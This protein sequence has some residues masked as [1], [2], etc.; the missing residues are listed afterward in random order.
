M[1]KGL[2]LV[3]FL[4]ITLVAIAVAVLVPLA[5]PSLAFWSVTLDYTWKLF[6]NLIAISLIAL[7]IA[8]LLSPLEALGWWAGWYKS[9]LDTSFQDFSQI[10]TP[11]RYIER[12][13]VYLDGIN[14]DEFEYLENVEVF[15][16]QL[17]Q[18]LPNQ[19][20]LGKQIM[21]YSVLN[22]SLVD[23]DRPL[24]F[25]W[26]WVDWRSDN[27]SRGLLDFFVN[28]RNV[29]IVAV[30]A[31]RRYGPIYN[32]GS[33]QVILNS[34]LRNGYQIGSGI[35]VTL[36]GYSGGA[37]ISAGAAAYLRKAI[38]APIDL[39]SLG[40]VISGNNG[41]SHL[42]SVYH[43]TSKK[44]SVELLGPL[45]FPGRRRL[46]FWSN[47]NRAKRLGKVKIIS[48]GEM[49]HNGVN[50]YLDARAILPDGR[51]HLSYTLDI[52]REILTQESPAVSVANSRQSNYEIYR[53][54]AFNQP[55]Y[56]PLNQLI[57]SEH[58]QPIGSWMGRLILPMKEQRQAVNGVLF[59]VYHAAPNYLN[60]VGRVVN[61]RWSDNPD[62]QDYV[63]RVTRD[64][65]FSE[66]AYESQQRG[67]LHPDRLNNWYRVDPLESLAGARPDDNVLVMLPEP[68]LVEEKDSE[69]RQILRI[70]REPIQIS[71]RF[72]GLV[73]ILHSVSG[74]REKFR[75]IH[76]NSRSG[77]FD[78]R[79]EIV[80]IPQ[81][82][83]NR[84][85]AFPSSNRE[86][87]KSDLNRSGWYIY[88]A[89]DGRGMF[90]VQAIAP[91]ALFQLELDEV[92]T[93]ETEAID[94]IRNESWSQTR[95]QK[96]TAKTTLLVPKPK[97]IDEA[98]SEWKL[99]DRLIVMHLFG[100][101]GGQKGEVAP[102]GIYFGHFAFGV[103]QIIRD[104]L[105]EELRFDIDYKQVYA[106]NPDGI[107]SGTM[108]WSKYMGDR[109]WGWL[110][111]RPVSDI[112]VKLEAISQDYDFDGIQLSPW[113]EFIR[114]LDIMAARYRIGD[115]QG[116]TYVGPANSCV[117][118]SFQALY[119]AVER[120][121]AEIASRPYIQDWLRRYP[122]HPQTRRYNQL[123]RLAQA[124]E[125]VLVPLGI[126]RA[127]W[128]KSMQTLGISSD[129]HPLEN[130]FKGLGSW[131]TML[132]RLAHDEMAEIFLKL[133]ASMWVLRTNQVG[134]YDPDIEPIAP[135]T[136]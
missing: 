41:Y 62:I 31:D 39:I 67:N 57:T 68:V 38:A 97:P 45:L 107:I 2:T 112:L 1:S 99:G 20:I 109:Q 92:V 111:N 123:V 17:A 130:F 8:A 65:N 136:L 3:K 77:R 120:I 10:A 86:I 124:L 59:E 94:Y 51:S 103:A 7:L 87:E 12:Y 28:L 42:R 6:V 19:V 122:Y 71:G 50:G 52:I 80:R 118:D 58:Y 132:P 121:E 27:Y 116:G 93:G 81:V 24:D 74:E 82:V 135:T 60:L 133:G 44:D 91:R 61:L 13:I 79:E 34:L 37:Q 23:R 14:Q 5:S 69:L 110:G 56:Y 47:W 105:T 15:L 75:V 21:A 11:L 32:Q 73:R 96:G 102:M 66:K 119:I 43:L 95:A 84:K 90:V 49:T 25:L 35:P 53:Q 128:Q 106:Q 33:A 83:A 54:A 72:Y 98:I 126:V 89:M 100:G 125:T 64:V 129:E 63:M 114:Q 101:I 16:E 22:Q 117:Q 127:D 113:N 18:M 134:G 9:E 48:M 40:G 108:S 26:R 78:D 46:F 55:N 30:S 131:R 4:S 36:L 104:R 115:G 88:G 85:G 76:F 29:L 70:N